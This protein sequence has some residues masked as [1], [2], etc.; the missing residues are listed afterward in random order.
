MCIRDSIN[1]VPNSKDDCT[2]PDTYFLISTDHKDSVNE[3]VSSPDCALKSV[4]GH[5]IADSRATFTTEKT[6]ITNTCQSDGYQE[7]S[8]INLC[9]LPTD[10]SESGIDVTKTYL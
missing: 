9:L 4:S 5:L 10:C 2:D 6:C 1:S 3:C 8:T 7:D